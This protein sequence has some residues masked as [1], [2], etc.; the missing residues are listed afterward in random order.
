MIMEADI[1]D[2][3]GKMGANVAMIDERGDETI[4]YVG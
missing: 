1:R 4:H 2:L 3:A